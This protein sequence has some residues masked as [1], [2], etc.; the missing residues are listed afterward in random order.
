MISNRFVFVPI[1]LIIGGFLGNYFTIPLFFGADF[2][3]GSIAVLLVLYFYGLT[4]GLLA[5]AIIHAYTFV[6]WGHPY[7]I[8]NFTCEALFVGIFLHRGRRNIVVLD[9]LFWL[10]IGM[11]LV[12]VEHGVIMHMDIMTTFF[13][14]L[15]QSVNGVF[16]A[17][18]ASLIV[19]YLPMDK[20][21][22][23]SRS[24]TAHHVP[25]VFI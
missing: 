7:G 25:D 19:C 17:L 9:G 24:L 5:A 11:P 13:I 20:L 12:F 2:L 22:R 16:N 4:W 8:V 14:M 6:L 3:F 21:L 1:L 15:K 10:L 18:L 23:R